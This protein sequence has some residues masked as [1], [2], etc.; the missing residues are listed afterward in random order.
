MS[1]AVTVSPDR[2]LSF[3]SAKYSIPVFLALQSDRTDRT[4]PSQTLNA[5]TFENNWKVTNADLAGELVKLEKASVIKYAIASFIIKWD[6]IRTTTFA[7][8][9]LKERLR[10][11][12]K[13]ES[14]YL[15][16]DALLIDKAA[17]APTAVNQPLVPTD[18]YA[19]WGFKDEDFWAMLSALQSREL[20]TIDLAEVVITWLI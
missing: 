18:F 19:K 20:L 11:A 6:K 8:A 14:K 16:Y 13:A 4:T 15:I 9:T 3:L 2:I 12:T 7:E 1:T 5:D 10:E 17:S